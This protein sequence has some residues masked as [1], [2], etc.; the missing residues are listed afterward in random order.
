LQAEHLGLSSDDFALYMRGEPVLPSKFVSL[1]D[2]SLSTETNNQEIRKRFLLYHELDHHCEKFDENLNDFNRRLTQT[3]TDVRHLL[4]GTY[5]R[6][7]NLEKFPQL[8]DVENTEQLEN[9]SKITINQ[10]EMIDILDQS[11]SENEHLPEPLAPEIVPQQQ[12][13]KTDH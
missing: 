6:F 4:N 2:S 12:Q 3:V 1:F 7:P 13:T 8:I 5:A 10:K 9:L 11:T